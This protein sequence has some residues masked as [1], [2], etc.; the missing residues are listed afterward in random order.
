MKFQKGKY[1]C[2]NINEENDN[3]PEYLN[4]RQANLHVLFEEINSSSILDSKITLFIAKRLK[5]DPQLQ[6]PM[7]KNGPADLNR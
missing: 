7:P 1:L 5:F 6:S 2:N 4:N 3:Y